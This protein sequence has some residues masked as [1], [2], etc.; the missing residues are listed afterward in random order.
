MI[1]V[2]SSNP[3]RFFVKDSIFFISRFNFNG[4]NISL[5]FIYLKSSYLAKSFTLHIHISKPIISNLTD[6]NSFSSSAAC[7]SLP[8]KIW[9]FLTTNSFLTYSK[10]L[11]AFITNF[12]WNSPLIASTLSSTFDGAQITTFL[13]LIST[14]NEPGYE[15][16]YSLYYYYYYYYYYYFCYW[17]YLPSGGVRVGSF[18]YTTPK[19]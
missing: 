8:G 5:F 18:I 7:V 10:L 17:I 11:A 19:T 16:A 1:L 14:F 13:K 12:I 9:I 6:I 2:R 15:G 4:L 3:F